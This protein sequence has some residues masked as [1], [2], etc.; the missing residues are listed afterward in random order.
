MQKKKKNNNNNTH[1]HKP[2]LQCSQTPRATLH[3]A[4]W[5]SLALSG[6]SKYPNA[7]W[8]DQLEQNLVTYFARLLAS[9]RL[10]ALQPSLPRLLSK[11]LKGGEITWY[12]GTM[13]L[14]KL[15]K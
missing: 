8:K 6:W 13:G 11:P 15:Q 14:C 5:Q 7:I 9:Q 2:L 12:T 3:V 4:A 1:T 10:T